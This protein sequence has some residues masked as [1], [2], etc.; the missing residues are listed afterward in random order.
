MEFSAK[1][2]KPNR[3]NRER[4]AVFT[5]TEVCVH[6]LNIRKAEV[7]WIEKRSIRSLLIDQGLMEMERRLAWLIG[8]MI[9]GNSGR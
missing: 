3:W 1:V 2:A 6:F 7:H 5:I 9:H 8:L 4:E